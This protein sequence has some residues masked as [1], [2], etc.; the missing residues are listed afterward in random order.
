MNAHSGFAR[1]AGVLLIAGLVLAGCTRP[2]QPQKQ[3]GQPGVNQ[4]TQPDPS[5]GQ[6]VQG[7]PKLTPAVM[8]SPE[9]PPRPPKG[10]PV[11][12]NLTMEKRLLEVAPGWKRE[13]WT[14]NGQV[15]APTIRVNQGDTVKVHIVNKD[16]MSHSIDFHA[17]RIAPQHGFQS[18]GNDQ[19]LSFE[20]VAKDAG[21]FVYHCGTGP[22]L[23]HIANGMY[24]AI[25]VDPPGGRAPAREMVLVQSEWYR[26]PNDLNDM[27]WG[28]PLAMAFNG[29]ANQYQTNPL[30]GKIGEPIR[31]Y[32]AN[33]GPTRF[34]SFHI[35]GAIFDTVEQ[36]GNP[37]NTAHGIQAYTVPPGGAAVFETVITDPGKY[38]VVTHSFA[39]AQ[40][41]AIG[42]LEVKP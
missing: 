33:I 27:K 36:D 40:L 30:Q 21:L 7:D 12:V 19:E 5:P 22:A 28:K 20:F 10:K 3:G 17:A 31:I 34:S 25:I 39:D 26:D 14:Y 8:A 38:T 4:P 18:I 16:L 9:A 15:P 2:S 13:V 29:I 23:M 35:V 6:P 1:L 37:K 42:T 24:G 41:G 11:E 32:M